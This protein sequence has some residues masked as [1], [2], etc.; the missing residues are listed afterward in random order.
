[1]AKVAKSARVAEPVK[2]PAKT[3]K[4]PPVKA[5][6]KKT[7]STKSEAPPA[8]QPQTEAPATPAEAPGSGKRKKA[9]ASNT[10]KRYILKVL[11]STTHEDLKISATA[12]DIMNTFMNDM[13]ERLAREA[14]ELV[15]RNKAATLSSK[16]IQTACKLALPGQ[17]SQQAVVE[18]QRAVARFLRASS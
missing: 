5:P 1:M 6:A 10:Y 9:A 14:A 13:F 7:P 3:M 4:K 8:A 18:G 16:D 2:V 11:R 12:M 17:L 15:R